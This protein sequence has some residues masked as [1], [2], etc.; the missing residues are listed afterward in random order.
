M[1]QLPAPHRTAGSSSQS[2]NL[3]ASR[4]GAAAIV[5]IT[6]NTSASKATSAAAAA[7]TLHLNVTAKEG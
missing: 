1:V 5:T 3:P 2:S 4:V 7:S 6:T